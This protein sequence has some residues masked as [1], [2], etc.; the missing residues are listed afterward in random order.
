MLRFNDPLYPLLAFRYI[1]LISVKGKG[2]SRFFRAKSKIC[3]ILKLSALPEF[4][5]LKKYG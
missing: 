4:D 5:V 2:L 3:K 1:N